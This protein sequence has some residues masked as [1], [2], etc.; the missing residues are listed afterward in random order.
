MKFNLLYYLC[1]SS[2]KIYRRSILY[3]A[4]ITFTFIERIF[5]C[6]GILSFLLNLS[7]SFNILQFPHFIAMLCLSVTFICFGIVAFNKHS[8]FIGISF[9]IIALCLVAFIVF[10]TY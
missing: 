2:L 4:P 9:F 3:E 5:L 7:I 6:L 1:Y 8:I 10:T